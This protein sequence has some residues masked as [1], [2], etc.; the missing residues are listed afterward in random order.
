[1]GGDK[2]IKYDKGVWDW[3]SRDRVRYHLADWR[4]VQ[5]TCPCSMQV[6]TQAK[7]GRKG[8]D[9]TWYDLVLRLPYKRYAHMRQTICHMFKLHYVNSLDWENDL[10]STTFIQLCS[11]G[12]KWLCLSVVGWTLRF[13]ILRKDQMRGFIGDQRLRS[14][15]TNGPPKK[16][17]T[18]WYKPV[19]RSRPKYCVGVGWPSGNETWLGNPPKRHKTAGFAGKISIHS[20]FSSATFDWQRVGRAFQHISCLSCAWLLGNFGALAIPTPT[21]TWTWFKLMQIEHTKTHAGAKWTTISDRF[22]MFF[23]C[24]SVLQYWAIATA[25]KQPCSKLPLYL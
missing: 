8:L 25:S 2:P 11:D 24:P 3:Q 12:S 1:M 19:T 4:G 16:S 9:V 18:L 23:V 20:W 5:T 7:P 14:G 17:D 6:D 22:L 15:N 10:Y 13:F 21:F